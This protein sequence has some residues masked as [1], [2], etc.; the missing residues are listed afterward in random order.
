MPASPCQLDAKGPEG[1]FGF[2][3]ANSAA[4]YRQYDASSRY[5]LTLSG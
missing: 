5:T 2:L 1:A 4:P 3:G